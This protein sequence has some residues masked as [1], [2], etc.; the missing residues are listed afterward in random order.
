MQNRN[1]FFQNGKKLFTGPMWVNFKILIFILSIAS[2]L[3]YLL[4][5]NNANTMGIA[6]GEMQYNIKQL[7]DKNRDLQNEASQLKAM[8]RIKDISL[9]QLSMVPAGTYQYVNSEAAT[10][11]LQK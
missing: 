6:I 7:Q 4:V 11:A 3:S 10:V 2:F 5:V 1:S 9:N 8:A